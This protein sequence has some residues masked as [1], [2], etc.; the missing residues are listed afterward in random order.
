MGGVSYQTVDYPRRPWAPGTYDIEI[1]DTPHKGG[2]RY[3]E[4]TRSRTWFRV[5]HTGDR[6]I[7]TGGASAGCMTIIERSQ[8]DQLCSVLIRDRKRDGV[9]VGTVEVKL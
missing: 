5:G 3:S 8:W 2:L 7:H 1:P 9:N 6:Y 4:A